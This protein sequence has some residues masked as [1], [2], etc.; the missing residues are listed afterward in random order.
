MLRPNVILLA[1]CVC[2]IIQLSC[3]P[4]VTPQTHSSDWANDTST[5]LSNPKKAISTFVIKASDN[6][7]LAADVTGSVIL[8]TIKLVFKQGTVVTNLIPT[9]TIV[10]A[11]I[12]PASQTPEDFTNGVLYTVTGTDGTKFSYRAVA[13]FK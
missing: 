10:G 12:D 3:K 9:I 4:Q 11:S 5:A 7:G 13:F 1:F 6:P 8:D 2:A